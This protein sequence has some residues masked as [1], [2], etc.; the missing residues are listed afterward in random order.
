[1]SKGFTDGFKVKEKNLFNQMLVRKCLTKYVQQLYDNKQFK[2]SLK[3][4]EQV[5]EKH[6]DHPGRLISFQTCRDS[7][8]EGP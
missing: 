1:M 4:C 5:L 2:Q 6:P 8:N 3:N 7:C